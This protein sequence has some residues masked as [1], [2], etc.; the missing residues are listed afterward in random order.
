[1]TQNHS[2]SSGRV[3]NIKVAVDIVIFTVQG[4]ALKVIL[5]QMKKKPFT[6]MWAFPG[7]LLDP[8]ESLD[9]A[10]KR[11]LVEKTGVKS[12]Y[13][14]QLYTFGDP[15]RDPNGR[16][17]STAYFA[18]VGG[19]NI[20]LMTT[21]KYSDV[22]WF[23]IKKLPKLAYDHKSVAKYALQ[24]LQWKLEYMN[25]AYSLLPWRFTLSELRKVYE[26]I[27]DRALDRRNFQRKI[28]SLKML[29][30]TPKKQMGKH[31][32]ARLYEFRTRKPMIIEVL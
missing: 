13:L 19:K 9:E 4:D 16:V 28:L 18:L 1:M 29:R 31:R 32:P 27:L 22:A 24:R 2:A 6:G 10:A 5:I 8:K 20:Q 26:I 12:P 15:K 23:D 11:E 25:I 7:G 14:E 21:A 3:Q 17:I 30:R